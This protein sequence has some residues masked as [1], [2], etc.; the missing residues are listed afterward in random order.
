VTVSRRQA[1]LLLLPALLLLAALVLLPQA[2][3][4]EISLGR[5]SP[6]GSV[7]H[8]WS[9]ANYARAFDPLYAQVLA[10]SAAMAGATTL[11]C[12]FAGFP[13]AYAMALRAPRAWRNRLLLLLMVPFW[14]SLLVRTYAW[15]FL[16]R[17]GGV[18][19][20]LLPRAP[21][22]LFTDAAVL[23]GQVYGELPF[24][25][26]PLFATLE[27]LDQTLLEAS[28]DL[29]ASPWKTLRHVTLPLAMPGILAGSALVFVPSLGAYLA[30]DL[31]GGARTAYAG[32]LIQSQFVVARDLPF[33][34]AL[35]FVLSAL[36]LALL[37]A[38]R[39]PLRDAAEAR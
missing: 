26:L 29:G 35:S 17:R 32:N 4:L 19:D 27:R 16:L 9:L 7:I 28:A 38:M 13:V 6:H 18:L 30:P 2:L 39:R 10:R 22:I 20:A 8:E 15:L 11:V 21:D 3:L 37:F 24:M 34:A 23:L 5:R 36:V 25:I 14:T 12:L 31:L 33:G 1:I